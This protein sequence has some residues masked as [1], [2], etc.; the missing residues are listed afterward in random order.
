MGFIFGTLLGLIG[1]GW[2]AY[3]FHGTI[4]AWLDKAE[5]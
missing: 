1:G 3:R 4:E 5:D 2:L